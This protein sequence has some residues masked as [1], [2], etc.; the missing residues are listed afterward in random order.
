VLL[1]LDFDG[2]LHPAFPLASRPPEENRR[3]SYLPR[4]ENW[5][6]RHPDAEVLIVSNWRLQNAWD[7]LASLFSVDVRP[8]LVGMTPLLGT[9]QGP[10]VRQDEI[11]AW[12]VA[13]NRTGAPWVALDDVR[14]LYKPGAVLVVANDGFRAAEEAALDEAWSD[15]AHWAARHPVPDPYRN[16]EDLSLWLP[17]GDP[18]P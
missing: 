16:V 9:G 11:E 14:G 10:G 17:P 8:R 18:P 4:L 15:P 7:L 12:L 3:W 5:L 6:R 13:A 1:A 2:V